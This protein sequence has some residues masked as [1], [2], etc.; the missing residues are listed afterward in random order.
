[1]SIALIGVSSDCSPS[2]STFASTNDAAMTAPR[3]HH[4]SPIVLASPT[5]TSTPVSTAP[6]RT[7]PI[8]RVPTVDACTTSNAVS[9]AVRST[10]PG[11]RLSATR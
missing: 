9:G 6:T 11:E 4:D 5:A 8:C 3:L 2:R 7:R 1:M 10:T